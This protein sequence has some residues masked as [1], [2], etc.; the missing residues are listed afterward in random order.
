MKSLC[1]NFPMALL[2][3][4][5]KSP[6]LLNCSLMLVL[7]VGG[8]VGSA[9]AQWLQWGGPDRNFLT[10]SELSVDWP[11]DGP[12]QL[13][14]RDLGDGYSCILEE[15][16]VLYT[17]YRNSDKEEAI[18]ALDANSGKTLW[19]HSYEAKHR[20]DAEL[21]FGR[22]PNATPLLVGDRIFAAG[23]NAT[24][25]CVDK[26]KGTV[27][28]SKDLMKEYDGTFLRFGYSSSPLAYQDLIIVPL[29]GEG[30]GLL[31][32]KQETGEVVWKKHSNANGYSSP[33]LASVDGQD[34]LI[35]FMSTNVMGVDPKTGD[36]YWSFEHDEEGV[37]M[38]TP[39]FGA[40]NLLYLATPRGSRTIKLVRSEGATEVE[41]VWF[42]RALRVGHNNVVRVGDTII[43]TGTQPARL[44]GMD[45]KTGSVL[46]RKR[47]FA[48]TI[49]V[50]A[51]DH[52]VLLDE[53]GNLM[54]ATAGEEDFE[55]HAKVKILENPSWTTPT[56]V[57]QRLYVRDKKTI[58]GYELPGQS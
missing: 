7:I 49:F 6:R 33:I 23:I 52:L 25:T 2:C 35:S 38:S 17:M 28:W 12:K 46:F 10:T 26:K 54:I 31:A 41:E 45:A 8:L 42:S 1:E 4:R 44:Y 20:A 24:V 32:M 56:L 27:Q 16:G 13:W 48:R 39:V 15:D 57:G 11:E 37:G 30:H 19:E 14:T 22:G 36:L 29:G 34:Q 9:E 40:D 58:A 53:E 51:S 55:I 50:G 5:S 21:Q 18:I 3:P 47:G 43:A